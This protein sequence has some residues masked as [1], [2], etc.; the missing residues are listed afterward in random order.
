M[1]PR[2]NPYQVLN[3]PRGASAD[4]VRL[5]FRRAVLSCHPDRRP[6]DPAMAARRFRDVC[7]AY[8]LLLRLRGPAVTPQQLARQHRRGS[9]RAAAGQRWSVRH[10]DGIEPTDVPGIASQVRARVD[11]PVVFL[12]CLLAGALLAVAAGGWGSAAF[13]AVLGR[14]PSLA[15]CL[16][17]AVPVYLAV[18]AA[19]YVALVASR[20]VVRLLSHLGLTGRPTLPPP[21]GRLPRH[22]R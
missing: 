9:V 19:A 4:E 6:D 1:A 11:E 5:A 7:Q 8:R 10:R 3:V 17:L 12:A 2:L 16:L 14:S 18:A 15:A 13:E 22:G 21:P 20:V